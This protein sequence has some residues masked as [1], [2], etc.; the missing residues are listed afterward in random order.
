MRRAGKVIALQPR[1]FQV[2]EFLMQ[3][4]N[5]VVT[6]TMILEAVWHYHFTPATLVVEFHISRLRRKLD[7]GFDQELIY[8]YRGS[9]Y[10]I[11]C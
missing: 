11:G 5:Q 8:T 3:H 1:E 2:L 9:G 7:R 6:R 4:E 10:R